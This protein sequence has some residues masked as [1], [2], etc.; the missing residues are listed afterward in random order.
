[1]NA[2]ATEAAL[3]LADLAEFRAQTYRVVSQALLP[4]EQSRSRFIREA[5]REL[6]DDGAPMA[7]FAVYAQWRA[8]LDAVIDIA[9]CD[10]ADMEVHYAGLFTVAAPQL[11]C[12]P[13]ESTYGRDRGERAGWLHAELSGAY[14]AAG[15]AVARDAARPPDHVAIELEYASTLCAQE[16]AAWDAGTGDG[17]D[18]ARREQPAVALQARQQAFLD[19]HL[20]AWLPRFAHRVAEEDRGPYAALCRSAVVF[21]NHDRDLLGAL[22]DEWGDAR[23]PLPSSRPV[24]AAP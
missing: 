11:R 16:A 19:R 15:L 10:R 9:I 17:T 18:D 1:M 14:A 20:C 3:S 5:A 8:L 13:Y 23:E 21:V 6:L 12:P 24:A 4:P 22:L 2:P 7:R